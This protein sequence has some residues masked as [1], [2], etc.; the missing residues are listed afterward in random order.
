MTM[1]GSCSLMPCW[2]W[3]CN[4]C[5]PMA[6]VARTMKFCSSNRRLDVHVTFCF[7]IIKSWWQR[8]FMDLLN[9]VTLKTCSAHRFLGFLLPHLSTSKCKQRN[10]PITLKYQD[11]ILNHSGSSFIRHTIES[12]WTSSR[13]VRRK[14]SAVRLK[15]CARLLP[16]AMRYFLLKQQVYNNTRADEAQGPTG[17]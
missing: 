12:S 9:Q 14:T 4:T 13:F 16:F 7:L 17:T 2:R 11:F 3:L 8:F 15:I 10:R 1:S 6:Q 5:K